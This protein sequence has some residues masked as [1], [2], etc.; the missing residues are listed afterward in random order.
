M[1]KMTKSAVMGELEGIY[2]EGLSMIQ[3]FDI[4]GTLKGRQSINQQVKSLF[5][6]ASK[7]INVITTEAG[8]EDLH[9]NHFKTLKKASKN[10]VKLRVLTPKTDSKH[11]SAFSEIGDV[12]GAGK[13]M[14]RVFTVDGEHFMLALTDE[15]V[16]QS[17]DTA[18]WAG[19]GHVAKDVLEP[20]FE[21]FWALAK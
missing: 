2:K 16:H 15:K 13:P 5:K 17:Q 6:K 14:G 21:S 3:P 9:S 18:F 20:M 11:A 1:D 12:K 19:S 7:Y 10:G 8:L 4:A